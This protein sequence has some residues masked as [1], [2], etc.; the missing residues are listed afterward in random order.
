MNQNAGRKSHV[1]YVFCTALLSLILASGT[2]FGKTLR[3]PGEY[4]TIQKAIEAASPMDEVVVADGTWKGTGFKNLDVELITVRSEN[5]PAKCI[6]DCEGS[7][8][9][10]SVNGNAS[11]VSGFTIT[12][13]SD[14]GIGAGDSS[15]ISNCIIT[16]NV[17]D[18][19]GG[20]DCRGATIR[21]CIITDNEARLG[22]GINIGGTYY[23]AIITNCII[24]NNFAD[25]GAGIYS[26]KKATIS[27]CIISN[28]LA[29]SGSEGGGLYLGDESSI[30]NCVI[31]NN[32]AVR[33]GGF[34][35][36]RASSIINCTVVN[37]KS[38]NSGGGI[39]SYYAS[40]TSTVVNSILWGNTPD[41]TSGNLEI[42]YSDVQGGFS[43]MGNIDADPL[44]G[45]DY[46]LKAGSPC[47]DTGTVEMGAPNT[48]IDGASRPQGSGY[49]MG[50]DEASADNPNNP[51]A[52]AGSDQ[53]VG[54]KITL[55]GSKSF[56]PDG[57]IA[58]YQW[59]LRHKTNPLYNRTVSGVTTTVSDLK[60][61]FY[62][63]TL[64]V[65]DNSGVAKS[66][67]LFFSAIGDPAK[68]YDIN[69]DGKAGLAE[70]IYY[71]QI[72]SG[73]K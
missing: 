61:G 24:S 56:D 18:S 62:D 6:I 42:Y 52:N 37:N 17:G 9:A 48:D 26:S 5:G 21:D 47:I 64:T 23:S 34:H 51:S 71:L 68:E 1:K 35:I 55:D 28:N 16:N 22:G 41:Q 15:I 69:G 14:S 67:E 29:G 8:T 19:G 11:E 50:A 4:F 38:G 2:V 7:G 46:H 12:N 3:V 32:T 60:K 36:G 43:G 10:F 25:N 33:G 40:D 66:D 72:L 20:I 31:A 27:K 44:L 63:V 13:A 53:I 73:K 57:S 59:E 45:N 54:D 39:Y 30:T 58:S 49:D 70:V 65:T